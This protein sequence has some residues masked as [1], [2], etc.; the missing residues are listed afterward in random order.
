MIFK[1][2]QIENKIDIVEKRT[3]NVPLTIVP[4]SCLTGQKLARLTHGRIKRFKFSWRSREAYQL[5]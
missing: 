2:E 5:R 4:T 1:K 3:H